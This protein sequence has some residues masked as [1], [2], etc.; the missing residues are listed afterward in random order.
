MTKTLNFFL[1]LL[2]LIIMKAGAL[3]ETF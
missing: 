2:I 1:K 3:L